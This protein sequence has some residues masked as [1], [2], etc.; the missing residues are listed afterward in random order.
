MLQR[1]AGV[2]GEMLERSIPKVDKSWQLGI[3]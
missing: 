2:A 1:Q 3:T